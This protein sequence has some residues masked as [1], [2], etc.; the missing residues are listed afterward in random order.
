MVDYKT[1]GNNIYITNENDVFL[2]KDYGDRLITKIYVEEKAHSFC[3]H[4]EKEATEFLDEIVQLFSELLYFKGNK[5]KDVEY[6]LTSGVHSQKEST[7]YINTNTFEKERNH[8]F[9]S[10]DELYKFPHLVPW[11]LVPR[12]WDVIELVD[13]YSHRDARILEIGSGYGKNLDLMNKHGYK[14]VIGLE[15]SYNAFKISQKV[16]DNNIYGDIL[17]SGLNEKTFD[18]VLDIGCLH[19][20]ENRVDMA[21]SE[22]SRLLKPQGLIISRYFLPKDKEW[23][24]RYPISVERF[25]LCKTDI[26]NMFSLHFDVIECFENNSCVY[27]VGRNKT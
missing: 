21:V 25:G 4:I 2:V 1:I 3:F 7:V 19:C 14:H 13:K 11:N 26:M 22:V 8:K 20:I 12:E 9:R 24:D 17:H 6:V 15:K 23:L 16:V 10:I 5:K 18:L 27:F